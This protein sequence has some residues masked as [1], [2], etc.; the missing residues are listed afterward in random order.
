MAHHPEDWPRELAGHINAGDADAA[1]ALYAPDAGVV[2]PTGETLVGRN[3]IRRMLA[4]LVADKMK[5]EVRIVKVVGTGSGDEAMLYTE[6]VVTAND[7]SGKPAERRYRAIEVVREQADG[8]WALVLA[9][10]NGRG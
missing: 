6:W 5:M 3:P 7:A 9:D 10:P 4:Q 8:S 2:A 1:A